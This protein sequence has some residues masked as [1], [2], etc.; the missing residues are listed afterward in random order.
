MPTPVL[1]PATAQVCDVCFQQNLIGIHQKDLKR[2]H[3]RSESGKEAVVCLRVVLSMVSDCRVLR[4][5]ILKVG[6]R[7]KMY[8][9][10]DLH[11][12]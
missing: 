5:R 6:V 4:T 9:G 10:E 2:A 8:V 11:V 7:L 12:K 3:V 1:F